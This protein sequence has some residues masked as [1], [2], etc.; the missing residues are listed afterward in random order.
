M[1]H[2]VIVS[3]LP[4]G[5]KLY[6]GRGRPVASRTAAIKFHDREDAEERIT[7]WKGL[8]AKGEN[9][10]EVFFNNMEPLEVFKK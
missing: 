5:T 2:F 4:D 7:F 3:V 1:S 9:L 8:L 6:L 10:S